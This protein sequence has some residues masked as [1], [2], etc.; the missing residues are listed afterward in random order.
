MSW[1]C[2]KCGNEIEQNTSECPECGFTVFSPTGGMSAHTHTGDINP[3]RWLCGKCGHTHDRK[4][5]VCEECGSSRISGVEVYSPSDDTFG[6]FID[7][8]VGCVILL[9]RFGIKF[10]PVIVTAVILLGWVYLM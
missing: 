10:W 5:F 9:F 2:D 7:T 3:D 6:G 1:T 4:P 8:A